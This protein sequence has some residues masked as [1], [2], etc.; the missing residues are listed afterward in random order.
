MFNMKKSISNTSQLVGLEGLVK[1]VYTVESKEIG[2]DIPLEFESGNRGYLATCNYY[3]TR[4]IFGSVT[5]VDAA[6]SITFSVEALDK[7]IRNLLFTERARR[8]AGKYVA[9]HT[10]RHELRHAWQTRHNKA[11]LIN[12]SSKFALD[13]LE[14]YGQRP[15]EADA[16]QYAESIDVKQFNVLLE[17]CTLNQDMA[18]KAFMSPDDA[19]RAKRIV[20]KLLVLNI[21]LA[22]GLTK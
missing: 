22:L 5:Q 9:L 19:Q 6:H 2:I 4:S 21:K 13:A 7:V 3:V 14:G 1:S 18:G 15:Q 11:I 10:V 20:W 17:A 8:V 16:N 12:N